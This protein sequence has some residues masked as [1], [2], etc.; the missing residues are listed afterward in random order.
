[1]VLSETQTEIRDLARRF[2][3]EELRPKAAEW[4]KAGWLPDG[5]GRQLGELGF[6]SVLVPEELGGAGLDYVAYALITEELASGD[7]SVATLMSVHN[8]M[9][10]LPVL[11][12]GSE[13]QKKRWLP[14][15]VSGE[16]VG[17]FALTEP[18]AGSDAAA[19][20]TQARREGEG[21][22]L[23]GTK[24]FI[25]SGKRAG[26]TLAFA[27]T[28]KAAGKRG[29]S[30]FLVPAGTP[31]FSVARLEDKMGQKASDTAELNFSDCRLPA[32]ALLGKEGE[33]L[34]IA[35]ANLEAGRIGIAALSV[36]VA[37]AALELA[38]EFAKT[39]KTFGKPIRE[40]QAIAFRLA[41]MATRIEA[42]R[43]LVLSAAA[44][45]DA[46]KPALK[47]CAMAKLNA[48]EMA[49]RVVSDAL[50]IHGG[51]GFVKPSAIERLYRDIRVCRIYE[52][53]S[54]IQRIII[55]REMMKE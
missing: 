46:G 13:A 51:L 14:Q 41:D 53:T 30:A 26:L 12:F 8:S 27:V 23:D 18:D 55:A 34:K 42:A 7:A 1:M 35:L 33:G 37:S 28:D 4:E 36:G 39:R 25:S 16:I 44:T 17:A 54:D 45:K 48:S 3:T 50:Q 29:I 32:D 47:L 15:L 52:G 38:L 6:L 10:C 24:L 49:E 40:H 5:I 43:A 11:K 21:Y 9:S 22:V 31:G 20:R 2:S 19:I